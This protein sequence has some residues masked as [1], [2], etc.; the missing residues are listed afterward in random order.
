M[1]RMM[2]MSGMTR[3]EAIKTLQEYDNVAGLLMT[4]PHEVCEIA[5]A[6]MEKQIPKAVIN[7]DEFYDY[8]ECPN[9]KSPARDFLGCLYEY[10]RECGQR[11][12][13]GEEDD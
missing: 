7:Q 3:E 10:C 6:D 13:V 5:I 2:T 4:L 8:A 12:K 9:C 11:L 1:M